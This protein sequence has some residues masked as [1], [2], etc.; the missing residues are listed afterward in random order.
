MKTLVFFLEEL[1]A[2]EMLKG[3]LPRILPVDEELECVFVV[4]EGKHDLEREI[5][6]KLRG[7]M[8]PNSKFLILRDQDAGDCRKIK[9][10]LLKKCENAGKP[11]TLVRIACRELES[12]FLG[13]LPSV[14]RNFGLKGVARQQ[15]SKSFRDPD[16]L[17]QP[18]REL[19]RITNNS[20]QKVSGSRDLGLILSFDQNC[21]RSFGA[22]LDGVKKLV[23]AF[24]D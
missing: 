13:D 21:S 12:W 23:A 24:G 2:R 4:F 15:R 8:R 22:F 11:D 20:Y 3:L 5:E 14:E 18:S 6:R 1:S 16:H 9:A 10:N 17:G 19:A 7:W